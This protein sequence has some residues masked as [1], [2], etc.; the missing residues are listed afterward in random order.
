MTRYLR[1]FISALLLLTSNSCAFAQTL[2]QSAAYIISGGFV[3][4]AD[5]KAI[6][7]DTVLVPA[8]WFLP[9]FLMPK[10][11]LKV[12]NRKQCILM[13]EGVLPQQ[14]NK[15][16]DLYLNNVILA[17][18]YD[19]SSNLPIFRMFY[20]VG[21][22]YVVCTRDGDQQGCQRI[23][24][25]AVKTVNLPRIYNAV[26]YLYSNFCVSATRKGAF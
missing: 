7:Q 14:R 26:K 20:L 24:A 15:H 8:F 16:M 22:E 17:E 5:I 21:E 25:T 4:V 10:I 13:S 11:T 23:L 18:T 1:C 19:E 3:D 9:T 12:A 2:E 6:D